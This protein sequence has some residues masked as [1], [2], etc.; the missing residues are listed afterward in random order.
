MTGEVEA[1][2]G[3]ELCRAGYTEE[4]DAQDKGLVE[5]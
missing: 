1:K 3:K 2:A 5:E 4:E